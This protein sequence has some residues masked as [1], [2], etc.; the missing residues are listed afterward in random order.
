VK[1]STYKAIL[2]GFIEW[3]YN[4]YMQNGKFRVAAHLDN[5]YARYWCPGCEHLHTIQTKGPSA[6]GFNGDYD[7]PTITQAF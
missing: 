1:S 2:G 6:W 5:L 7:N 4:D 3:R